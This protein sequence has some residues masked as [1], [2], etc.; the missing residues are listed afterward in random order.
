MPNRQ[1]S[2]SEPENLARPLLAQ[3]RARLTE[4]ANG[5]T[6]LLWALRRKLY[7]ELM[8]DERSKPMQRVALKRLKRKEQKVVMQFEFRYSY[9]LPGLGRS[10]AVGNGNWFGGGDAATISM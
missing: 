4:L 7:K 1:L 9:S 8:Y 10:A 6:E 5:D 2:A 3:V